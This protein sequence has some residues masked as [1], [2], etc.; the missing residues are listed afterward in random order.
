MPSR[1]CKE[2]NLTKPLTEFHTA[3]TIKGIKY[4]RHKCKPC[5]QHGKSHRRHFNREWLINY[6]SSLSCMHCG[7]SKAT[8]DSFKVQAL[9]FHHHKNDKTYIVSDMVHRGMSIKKI[10][11]E[12]SKCMVL[13]SRCHVEEHYK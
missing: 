3:G 4:F 6:K 5:Y 12:I 11:K 10:I 9:E 8:H 1:K 2:C 7:Y 13:C